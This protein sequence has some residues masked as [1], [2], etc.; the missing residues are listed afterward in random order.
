MK[1]ILIGYL[2][3]CILSVFNGIIAPTPGAE[4]DALKFLGLVVMILNGEEHTMLAKS[5]DLSTFLQIHAF[6]AKIF[7]PSIIVGGLFSA[8]IW[9]LSALII[10]QITKDLKFSDEDRFF[11]LIIYCFFPSSIM[12]TSVMLREVFQLLFVNL[13]FF[14]LIK[15]FISS[16]L[17]SVLLFVLSIIT[18]VIAAQF[19]KGLVIFATLSV[20]LS[21][22]YLA[23]LGFDKLKI[24]N[25]KIIIISMLIFISFCLV[26]TIKFKLESINFQY[27]EF[28]SKI[29]YF[30][31]QHTNNH[32]Y[33][34]SRATYFYPKDMDSIL[35]IIFFI[36][37]MFVNYFIQPLPS[38]IDTFGDYIAFFENIL[39]IAFIAFCIF[40]SFNKD[41]PNR[42]IFI[43][44]FL[45]F[46]LLELVWSIGTVNYGTA[47]RHHIP[48]LG[49]ILICF[50][51]LRIAKFNEKK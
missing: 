15:S 7:V 31:E 36:P 50:F 4:V 26:I 32:F 9:L 3:R 35:D 12:I 13:A 39:R 16:K 8:F 11:C 10:L 34:F 6:I 41:V 24:P 22:I 1:I 5:D 37:E 23:I 18:L 47:I 30:F 45:N 33:N 14:F 42:K 20:I 46:L 43:L 28:M 2:I 17:K 48:G 49:L 51:N 40:F 29:I 21:I 25:K 38:N 19:H 44:L 27:D